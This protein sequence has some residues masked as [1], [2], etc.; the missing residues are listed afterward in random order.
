METDAFIAQDKDATEP[1]RRQRIAE[2]NVGRG[3][4]ELDHLHG[5]TWDP[6]ELTAD[7]EVMGFMAPFVVVRRK[8]DRAVGSLE[9]QHDPRLYFN[10]QE[11]RR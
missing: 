5:K 3:R 11:D 2:L 4:R 7:F 1:I 6:A 9:F 10:W 8:S